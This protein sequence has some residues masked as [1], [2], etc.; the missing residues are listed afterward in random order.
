M[1]GSD[2]SSVPSRKIPV[3]TL[4]V[5]IIGL[6]VIVVLAV[7]LATKGGSAAP[8]Q[9][10]VTTSTQATQT[11]VEAEQS[12]LLTEKSF[13]TPEEAITFFVG[14]VANNDFSS[15]EQ[16]FA[17]NEYAQK[18]DFTGYAAYLKSLLPLTM[19]APPES[20]MYVTMNRATVL[21]DLTRQTKVFVYSF[22]ETQGLDASVVPI[23]NADAAAQ[24]AKA[25]DPSG[26]KSLQIGG[27]TTPSPDQ[28]NSAAN[29]AHFK[30]LAA[31]YGADN[32]A[33]RAV[34]YTLNG[35]IFT[36]G[37]GLLQYGSDWKIFRFNSTLAGQPSTGAVTKATD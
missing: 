18:F 16:A 1:P 12:G 4:V 26:L 15:A 8:A 29:Q 7:L 17:V 22:F 19:P 37:F 14:A 3:S 9:A 32:M 2:S 23:S 11:T 5:G 6:A 20:P 10:T 21:G 27:I 24:F 36:G 35:Q 28:Y 33:E 34:A 25:V 30:Q 13:A 31:F